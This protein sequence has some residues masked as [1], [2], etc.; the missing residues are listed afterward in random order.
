MTIEILIFPVLVFIAS[1]TAAKLIERRR[2]VLYGPYI[3]GRRPALFRIRD[4][5]EEIIASTGLRRGCGRAALRFA[6]ISV[7][8]S[9]II[10]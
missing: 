10:G 8:A 1:T 4:L 3:Q 5:V 2:D 7:L 6:P 9:A